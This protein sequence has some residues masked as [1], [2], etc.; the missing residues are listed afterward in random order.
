[1]DKAGFWDKK[2][3]GWEEKRYGRTG[4]LYCR[5]FNRSVQARRELILEL[6]ASRVAGKVVLEIG[7]GSGR[8]AREVLKLG[9]SKYVGVDLSKVAIGK[10]KRDFVGDDRAEFHTS[11]IQDLPPVDFDFCFSAGLLDWL[12][13]SEIEILTEKT[14]DRDFLHSF[15]EARSGDFVRRI[16]AKY[17]HLKYGHATKQYVPRYHTESEIRQFFGSGLEIHRDPAMRFGSLVSR[18]AGT[19]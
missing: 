19:K 12:E 3:L 9:A 18:F 2:I 5:L 13:D 14:G 10:A 1:M 8:L 16:H 4:G 11:G 17:V 6:L 7:C 15:S